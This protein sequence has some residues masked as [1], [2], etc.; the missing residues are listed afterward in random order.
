MNRIVRLNKEN[1]N[2][3]GGF[4]E[5]NKEAEFYHKL[6]FKDLI[7]KSYKNYKEL[8]FMSLNETNTVVAVFPFFLSKSFLLGKGVISL[9]FLDSGNFLGEYNKEDIEHIL[10]EIK[11]NEGL[12]TIEIRLNSFLEK[13][14]HDS[15]ILLDLGF[16]KNRSKNQIILKLNKKGVMWNSF[17]RITKK[18]IRRAKKAGLIIKE[19]NSPRE[20][21]KFYVLYTKNMKNFGSPQHSLG[22]F[23]NLFNIGKKEFK[24]LNCYKRE[25]L[26]GSLIIIFSEKV[27]HLLYSISDSNFLS[28][29]PNDLLH[30][31][32]LKWC[33]KKGIRYFDFGQCEAGAE[34]GSHAEGILNFKKKWGGQIYDKY[35]FI[36]TFEGKDKKNL[37]RSKEKLKKFRNV[38]TR[39]PSFITNYFGPK[40]ISEL[41]I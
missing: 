41:G 5:N 24:G 38:W 39:M 7:E 12:K 32:I 40:V 4:V 15:K 21:K 9:P 36:Y 18:G 11:K 1:K 13:F 35:N 22:F 17:E 31:E 20:V 10:E 29:R 25:K 3:W 8:Y 28:D 37:G 27:A 6:W 23:L 2:L 33:S 16:S 34:I 14:E 19:I 26:I 30:W